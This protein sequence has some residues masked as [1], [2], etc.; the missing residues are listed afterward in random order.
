MTR[1]LAALLPLILLAPTASAATQ[2]ETVGVYSNV[3]IS[4]SEDPHA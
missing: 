3:R 2:V 4:H 1:L